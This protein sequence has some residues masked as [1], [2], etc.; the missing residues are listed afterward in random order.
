MPYS[1]HT[2]QDVFQNTEDTLQEFNYKT[3]AKF[4][5]L[6]ENKILLIFKALQI[7]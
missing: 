7:Y 5:N 4:K 2:Q 3:L 1:L 6:T